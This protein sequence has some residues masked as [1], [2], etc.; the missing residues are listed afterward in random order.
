MSRTL[1][2]ID[3]CV[4]VCVCVCVCVCVLTFGLFLLHIFAYLLVILVTPE[5]KDQQSHCL[6]L[7]LSELIFVTNIFGLGIFKNLHISMSLES[8]YFKTTENVT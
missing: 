3:V 6:H 1:F 2:C 7:I 8:Q 5:R 4:Y